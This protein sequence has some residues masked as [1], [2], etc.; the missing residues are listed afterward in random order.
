MDSQPGCAE[1]PTTNGPTLV[2]A[3]LHDTI[4]DI[5]VNKQLGWLE[6]IARAGC[7]HFPTLI[8]GGLDRL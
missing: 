3:S 6:R 2:Y 5:F 1:L 4:Y 8:W 7:S